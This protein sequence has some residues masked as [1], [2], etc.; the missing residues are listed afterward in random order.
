[1]KKQKPPQ[2]INH[3][4]YKTNKITRYSKEKKKQQI[5]A[6]YKITQMLLLTDKNFKAVITNMVKS[7]RKR[8]T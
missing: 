7:L 2:F 8:K 5:E 3:V 6:N 1:M 4:Y